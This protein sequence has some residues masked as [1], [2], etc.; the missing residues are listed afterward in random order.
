M[1]WPNPDGTAGHVM[2]DDLRAFA[3]YAQR[4]RDEGITWTLGCGCGSRVVCGYHREQNQRA[5]DAETA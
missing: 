2:S 4:I 3:T 1:L 5:R